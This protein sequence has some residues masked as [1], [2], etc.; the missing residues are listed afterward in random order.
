[1]FAPTR[2]SDLIPLSIV[3]NPLLLT[4]RKTQICIL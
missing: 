1:M 4:T 3:R 2:P